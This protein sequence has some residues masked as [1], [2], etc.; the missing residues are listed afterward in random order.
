MG[1]ISPEVRA[2]CYKE[3]FAQFRHLNEQM[4]KIPPFAVTL[5]GGFWYIAVIVSNYGE[6]LTGTS[7]ALAR[8][9]LM[10]F[11]GIANLALILIAVRI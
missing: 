8:F 3:N 2:T 5:T 1:S 7:E 11:S 10:I 9:A 4:N 6:G